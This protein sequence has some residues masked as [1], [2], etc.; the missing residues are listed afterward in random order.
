[1]MKPESARLLRNR[2]WRRLWF[3]QAV[4]I[5]GDFVFNTTVVLWVGTV[6][7]AD[8]SWAPAAV[9][10]VLLATAVPVLVVGP[11]SG[12]FVD[13]WNRL[14]VMLGADAT[15]AIVVA[16]L[17][18]IPLFG[19]SWP[20]AAKLSMIYAIVAFT[21]AV[22]Q[23]FNPA[24][25]AIIGSVLDAPD[26]AQAFGMSTATASAAAVLGPP[27]AAP[28]LFAAGVRWALILNSASYLISFAA[29]RLVRVK[30][31]P[32]ARTEE[33][34]ANFWAELRDGFRYFQ[35]S[36]ALKAVV[37]SICLYTLGVGA[38]NVLNVFFITQTLGLPGRWL[39]VLEAAFG[40]GSIAGA[41]ASGWF[42][43]T[44]G[45][46][47]LYTYGI[48]VTGFVV[49]GY[50]QSRSLGMAVLIL[51]LAG[52]P[53]ACVNVTIGPLILQA[54]PDKMLGRI[55]AVIN[56]LVYL[57]SIISA[58]I[59]GFMAST[60]LRSVDIKILGLSFGDVTTVFAV[61]ALIMVV[62]GIAARSG[63]RSAGKPP[64]SHELLAAEITTL[65]KG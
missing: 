35:G 53:L 21:S 49:F 23:F 26:R 5:L 30:T 34:E 38:I 55:N 46:W 11:L 47:R 24:R 39:G 17:L 48:L 6:I 20:I 40:V 9:G 14:R 4:S 1:M 12:V 8:R 29:T 42:A 60:V 7:A 13:R 37:Y 36:R 59:A 54:T 65:R 57:S 41:V 45:D 25:F 43:R 51:A 62:A 15:R 28:L 16:V 31:P 32:V 19:A 10:G 63:L 27:I 50:S 3:A 18:V 22:S 64:Q 61:A 2:N 52:V 33:Q 56:P 44:L 58:A